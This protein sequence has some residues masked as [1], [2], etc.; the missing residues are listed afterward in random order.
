VLFCLYIGPYLLGVSFT[1]APLGVGN[2]GDTIFLLYTV[3]MDYKV[4]FLIK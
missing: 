4:V 1:A 3:F 2:D